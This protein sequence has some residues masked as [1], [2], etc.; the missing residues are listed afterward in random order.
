MKGS[1]SISDLSNLP[2]KEDPLRGGVSGRGESP[3]EFCHIPFLWHHFLE[4]SLKFPRLKCFRL[5]SLLDRTHRPPFPN[6]TTNTLSH[7]LTLL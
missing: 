3:S 1:Q 4:K 5:F 6:N 2:P 7:K